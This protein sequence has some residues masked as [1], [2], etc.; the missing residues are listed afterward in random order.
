MTGPGDAAP[1]DPFGELA[2]AAVGIHE[3]FSSLVDGGFSRG[4]A[5]YLVSQQLLEPQRLARP[6]THCGRTRDT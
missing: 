1:Q 3:M 5:L 6:C 2:Q 4:E